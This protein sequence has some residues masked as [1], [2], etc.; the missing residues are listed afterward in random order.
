MDECACDGGWVVYAQAEDDGKPLEF[1]DAA[2]K[3][4]A[5]IGLKGKKSVQCSGA[6]FDG[7]DPSPD[8]KKQCFCDKTKAFFDQ[9]F[10]TATRQF[11]KASSLE[12]MSDSE[13]E[14]QTEHVKEVARVMK[15]KETAA[16]EAASAAKV[17]N[18]KA[19]AD[20]AAAKTCA[21]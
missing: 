15:E 16:K 11:W 17:E 13:L 9:N 5:V 18:D 6:F 7:A 1:F 19:L 10:V 14:R 20:I 3:S 8:G 12:K 21:A 4:M 2:K